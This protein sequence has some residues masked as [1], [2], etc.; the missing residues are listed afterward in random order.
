[1]SV[2]RLRAFPRVHFG[3]T[4]MSGATRR[5]YGGAGASFTGPSVL[6]EARSAGR[7]IINIDDLDDQSGTVVGNALV[8]ASDLGLVVRGK[9]AVLEQIP[10]HVG[11]GSTTATTLAVLKSLSDLNGWQ[12][13]SGR[14][15]HVSGRARTS[16]IGAHTF[17]EGGLVAD[18]GQRRNRHGN[19]F[20][21][22]LQPAGRVPSVKLARWPMPEDWHIWLCFLSGPPSVPPDREAAFFAATTPTSRVET[23]HQIAALYH[24]IVPAVLESDLN[25]FA[26]ALREFQQ[27]GFKARELSAQPHSVQST[28]SSLWNEGAAVGLSSLGPTVFVVTATNDRSSLPVALSRERVEG[29]FAFRNDGCVLLP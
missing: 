24:G 27:V 19:D 18:V 4:D 28:L 7:L 2:V 17:F 25:G 3:L 10:A 15:I 13:P 26:H 6:V 11:L 14:L 12:L 29:P 16:A 23:L 22:S 9:V 20:L 8:A 21:P 5:S 1:M